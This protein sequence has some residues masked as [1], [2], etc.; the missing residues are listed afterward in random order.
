MSGKVQADQLLQ[1]KS[2]LESYMS[3]HGTALVNG[4]AIAGVAVPL[5]P[6][7]AELQNLQMLPAQFNG[8]AT[9]NRSPFVTQLSILPAGCAL[10]SC[11]ISGYVY[12]RDPIL[13]T[14]NDATRGEYDGVAISALLSRIGGD[15]F[16][17]VVANG[18]LVASGGAFSIPNS[19]S[20]AHPSI[21]VSGQ[22]YPAGVAGVRL[23]SVSPPAPPPPAAPAGGG[24]TT[25]PAAGAGPACT[26]GNVNNVPASGTSG[27]GN[28]NQCN[29]AYPTLASG[30]SVSVNNSNS[31][32][33]GTLVVRCN[34]LLGI[35]A[36]QVVSM[37]CTK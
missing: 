27:N 20:V 16:A 13:D 10:G 18:S 31:S 32:T 11:V 36:I 21:T 30:Q 14:G 24:G 22:P 3:A 17:R 19:A 12:I 4:T 33:D 6:T 26:A 23:E 29:F 28:G 7:I 34:T 9:L 1:I 15:G 2:A 8:T 35:S 37:T 25:P 5:R